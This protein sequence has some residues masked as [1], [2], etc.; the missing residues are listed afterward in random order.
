MPSGWRT[1][2]SDSLQAGRSEVRTLMGRDLLHPSRPA[3][4]TTQPPVQWVTSLFPWVT[5]LGEGLTTNPLLAPVTAYLCLT[6]KPAWHDTGECLALPRCMCVYIL[7]SSCALLLDISRTYARRIG[8]A[9][10]QMG[11]GW[12]LYHQACLQFSFGMTQADDTRIEGEIKNRLN[13]GTPC[14]HWLQNLL[15]SC[16]PYK[17]IN[18]KLCETVIFLI[19]YEWEFGLVHCGCYRRGC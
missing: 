15:S 12:F 16:L 17:H 1:R 8:S 9:G 10:C 3:P 4:T 14:C 6:S 19:L 11:Q 7:G 5:L 2:Y 18:I 13:S